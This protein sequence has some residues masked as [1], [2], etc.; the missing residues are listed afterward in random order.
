MNNDKNVGCNNKNNNENTRDDEISL[1]TRL[2]RDWWHDTVNAL[3]GNYPIL[4]VVSGTVLDGAQITSPRDK[5]KV[6]YTLIQMGRHQTGNQ[7]VCKFP[8]DSNVKVHWQNTSSQR[9]NKGRI[10]KTPWRMNDVVVLDFNPSFL[11][12][13][14]SSQIMFNPLVLIFC[15]SNRCHTCGK[16]YYVALISQWTSWIRQ[17]T[18]SSAHNDLGHLLILDLT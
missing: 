13:I 4:F 8:T 18:S 5:R 1:H 14:F 9:A 6:K 11:R 16:S 17:L 7:L 10:K 12:G 15:H 2:A 3:S